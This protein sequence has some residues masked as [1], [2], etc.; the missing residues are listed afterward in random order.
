MSHKGNIIK[1]LKLGMLGYAHLH[2]FT[3]KI[4]IID[5][6]DR[7]SNNLYELIQWNLET[8]EQM[9]VNWKS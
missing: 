6:F 5:T 1:E 2:M 4:V 8:N 7:N 3:D 9:R